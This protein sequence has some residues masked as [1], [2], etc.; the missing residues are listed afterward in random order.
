MDRAAIE[1]LGSEHVAIQ[2][3]QQELM[4]I[5]PIED[6]ESANQLNIAK[7]YTND[8]IKKQF[9]NFVHVVK[10]IM[11]SVGDVSRAGEWIVKFSKK[12][13]PTDEFLHTRDGGIKAVRVNPKGRNFA[14]IGT[15]EQNKNVGK[16]FSGL[17][18]VAA[19]AFGQA[20]LQSI[21]NKLDMLNNKLDSLFDLLRAND[22]GEV[23]GKWKYLHENYS[24][25]VKKLYT[26][27]QKNVYFTK[28]QDLEEKTS[29]L[30]ERFLAQMNKCIRPIQ[31]EQANMP[32]VYA[33]IED[34][35]KIDDQLDIFKHA[36]ELFLLSISLKVVLVRLDECLD[37]GDEKVN[38]QIENIDSWMDRF[39]DIKKK[40][41]VAYMDWYKELLDSGTNRFLK[42]GPEEASLLLTKIKNI[43]TNIISDD[44]CDVPNIYKILFHGMGKLR[45][46]NLSWDDLKGMQENAFMKYMQPLF[47]SDDIEMKETKNLI[48]E[49]I[50]DFQKNLFDKAML[51]ESPLHK[52]E[53]L[54]L[55]AVGNLKWHRQLAQSPGYFKVGFDDAGN[56]LQL[57]VVKED[58][59]FL[60]VR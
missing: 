15:M 22:E 56:V 37:V 6:K 2:M 3:A 29:E 10:P 25:I 17:F 24:T 30:I 42:V 5:I 23:F 27:D 14:E 31:E 59:E 44:L 33:S 40:I 50:I 54:V 49:L 53:D 9:S 60:L 20:Y 46:A 1:N 28:V 18:D 57:A 55:A 52:N 39:V 13:I 21:D 51:E 16:I 11:D 12:N 58:A 19:V 7:T 38:I 4:Q 26:R 41:N 8:T 36:E 34:T 32:V 43:I 45:E 47:G 35:K 48:M